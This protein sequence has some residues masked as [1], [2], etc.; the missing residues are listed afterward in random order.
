MYKKILVAV[1]GSPTSLRGLDEAVK[2]ATGT[3]GRLLL[4]HVVNELLMTAD[5]VPSV[6]YDSIIESLRESGVKVLEQAATI[7]RRAEVSSEPRLVETLGGRV[8]DEIV[9]QA[10]EW[11][12][13]LIVMGTHG[14]RGLKR[15]AMGSDA[16][17]VLRL[18]PVPVL[19]IRDRPEAT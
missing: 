10:K 14:R 16:E 6:Y 8:A 3:G 15:L 13:D 4:V 18:S 1:D 17:L 12:A 2:V 7:V 5:A 9:K 11:S 19:L